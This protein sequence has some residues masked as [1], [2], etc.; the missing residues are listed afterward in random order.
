MR[1]V[2]VL[3]TLA[4]C[5]GPDLTHSKPLKRAPSE[6]ATAAVHR[7]FDAVDSRNIDLFTKAIAPNFALFEDGRATSAAGLVGYW[8]DASSP[9]RQRQCK[10][11]T[12]RQSH[13]SV[14][15]TGDCTETPVQGGSSRAA[16]D[17]WQGWNTVVLVSR[18]D[19]W[20]VV[21]WQ[22]QPSGIAGERIRWNDAYRRGNSFSKEPTSFLVDSIKNAVPGRALV[23][24][25]GQGRNALY[26]ATQGWQVT[27]V[28][29]SDIGIAKAQRGNQTQSVTSCRGG[30]H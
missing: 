6:T 15:Y 25:M 7:F 21:F 23:L 1:L 29:L 5:G 14:V 2:L 13:G 16:K 17:S 3:I 9:L 19:S 4:A 20:D 30:R 8:D 18:D 26:L 27:G 24:A 28:D 12:I 10:S 22:W 11:E